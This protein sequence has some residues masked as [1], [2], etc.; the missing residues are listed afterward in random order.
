VGKKKAVSVVPPITVT[1]DDMRRLNALA[2]SNEDFSLGVARILAKKMERATEV[3]D[4]TPLHGII[5]MGSRVRYF[6]DKTGEVRDVV[7][8]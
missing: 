5:R 7:L 2:N 1:A 4:S 3:E 8:V 6:D